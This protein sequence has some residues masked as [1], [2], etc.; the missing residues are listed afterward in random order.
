MSDNGWMDYDI[1]G[2]DDD[3]GDVDCGTFSKCNFIIS[4]RVS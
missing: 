4:P 3:D 2:T 1:N